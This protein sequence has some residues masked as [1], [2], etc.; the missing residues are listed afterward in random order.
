MK[1][2][3]KDNRKRN[4]MFIL[5]S[6]ILLILGFAILW[7]ASLRLPDLADLADR[8]VIQSTKI[9]D[10]TGQILL[11]DMSS[12]VRRTVVPFDS[13]APNLKKA[14]LAIEDHD[15]Y[16]HGGVKIS[17]F[18]RA[19]FINVASLSYSQGG[20]TITQQVVKNAILNGDKTP[21]RKIKEWILAEKL[22]KALSKD[23]I[24]D[25]Y[26]NESPYGG[27]IYGVEEASLTFF[28]KE[29]KN[30]TLT[31]AA[32]IASMTKAPTYYSPYGSH[33]DKLEERKNLVLSNMLSYGFITQAEFDEAMKEKVVFSPKTNN[34]GLKAPHFVF[35]V[36]DYIANKFGDAA[37]SSGG[38][39]ITTTLDY[40]I[41]MKMEE[42]AKQYGAT[43]QK[44]FNADNNAMVAMDPKTGG[45]LGMTG[46]RDYF[47]NK[48]NGNF[49]VAT[50]H[51]QPGS[52]FKPFVY[53]GLFN[54]GYTPDTVLFDVPTQFSV[55][56]ASSNH[57]SDNGCYS[58]Q[59]FDGKFHGPISI[60]NAL[61]LSLNIPAVKA[62][63]LN[64]IQDSLDTA[65]SL[66][67]D[68]LGEAKQYG[69]TLVL[70][71]G[72]VSPLEMTSAYSVFANDGVRNPVN[73]V[74]KIQDGSGNVTYEFTPAPIE[75]LPADTA[76][77]ISSILSDNVARSPEYGLVSDLYIPDRPVAV[78][79]G[80]TNDS[81]DAWIIG[82]APNLV[83]GAWVGNNE[84]TPMVKKIAGFIVAPMWRKVMDGI[85]PSFPI[86]TFQAPTPTDPNLKPIL[87][88]DWQSD[89]SGI[90]SILYFVNKKDPL[91]PYPSNPAS[92]AEFN[93]WEASVRD[94]SYTYTPPAPVITDPTILIDPVTGLPIIPPQSTTSPNQTQTTPTTPGA[95]NY[96]LTPNQ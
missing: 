4:R 13:I 55:N 64:G 22:D 31:E 24:L 86:E 56:C 52:T 96:T 44:N 8:R 27:S 57:T 85:L 28:G 90:H 84:N 42:A 79:T 40:N 14:T 1:E 72:E 30:V 41:Q 69:L 93:N 60:R 11:Y 32:Y 6:V 19:L 87:R 70:G 29:A 58:P 23:Q 45:I 15:F 25:I 5:A 12:D 94:W 18:I 92:D 66:G 89:P 65:K 38:M 75:V 80:T 73:P 3:R 43:N 34:G 21:T 54:K 20:S 7:V 2:R 50:A 91:G 83:L 74:L 17:S 95:N 51:R 88:G 71:G 46:S 47:D 16:N 48:I 53:A 36:I 35:Y 68:S 9:Y 10:K 33:K 61:A 37:I 76:R 49:N 77:K 63:Y 82:Y 39:K 26:L 59:N 81:K 62:L 78:K 67:I